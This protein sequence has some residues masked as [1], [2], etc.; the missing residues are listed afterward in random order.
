M[1]KAKLDVDIHHAYG[2]LVVHD[3]IQ[4]TVKEN[5]FLCICGP[6]GCGKTTLLDVLSGL[7]KPTRGSVLLDGESVDPKKHS[8]SFVFQEPST[9]PWLTVWENIA[10]GL[11][12]KKL[13]R[14]EIKK[15]VDEVI[16]IVGLDDVG[17]IQKITNIVSGDLKINMSSMSIDTKEGLFDGSIRVFVH[18]REELDILCDRL[19]RI[20]DIHT[21]ERIEQ[22][23]D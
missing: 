1:T 11:K 21:V 17:I 3:G 19:S 8:I 6:S 4:F 9:L 14:D 18:D 20:Q 12:I 22:K 7:L 10:T 13:P 16:R 23:N 2:D 5:E 15:K